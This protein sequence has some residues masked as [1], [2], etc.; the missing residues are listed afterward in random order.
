MIISGAY[1]ANQLFSLFD[2]QLKWKS[3]PENK[4]IPTDRIGV[5]LDC[6]GE[7]CDLKD[8][9]SIGDDFSCYL[10][11]HSLCILKCLWFIYKLITYIILVGLV[12]IRE[13]A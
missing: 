8:W 5:L 11:F 1:K 2:F 12:I 9:Y 10:F 6:I 4:Y 7:P 13:H 3:Q